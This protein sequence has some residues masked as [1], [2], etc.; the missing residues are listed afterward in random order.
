M[1]GQN[2]AQAATY[3]THN[4]RDKPSIPSIGLKTTIPAITWLQT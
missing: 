3:T 2:T 1:S 4:T